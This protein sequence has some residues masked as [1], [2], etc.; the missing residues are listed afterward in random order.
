MST[1]RIKINRKVL[2]FAQD[3]NLKTKSRTKTKAVRPLREFPGKPQTARRTWGT[4]FVARNLMRYC[5][6]LNTGILTR[7]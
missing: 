3:D 7:Q 2:R 5:R 6:L 4:R 1:V